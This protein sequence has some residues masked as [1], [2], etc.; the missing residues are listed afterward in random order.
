MLGLNTQRGNV[1]AGE[2]GLAALPGRV[3]EAKKYIDE[4]IAYAK[5]INCTNVHIM[6]GKADGNEA[7]ATF[8]AN[9]RYAATQAA[10]QQTIL[11]EPL[12]RYDMPGYFLDS[13][14]QARQIINEVGATNLK[15]MFDCYHLQLQEGDLSNRLQQCLDI[16]GHIQFA[17][18]PDRGA[19]DHGEINYAHIFAIIERLGYHA[20]LGAEYK[21]TANDTDASLAWLTTMRASST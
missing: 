17:A 15:L 18:V 19:P 3:G 16:I 4:A 13:T 5:A 8:V 10:Q 1:E 7:H 14:T 21:P 6:A 12:N 2:A 9:L 20:P 11:I